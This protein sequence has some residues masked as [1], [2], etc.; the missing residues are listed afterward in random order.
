M[1]KFLVERYTLVLEDWRVKKNFVLERGQMKLR[2][3]ARI[4]MSKSELLFFMNCL[5]LK[6]EGR[7]QNKWL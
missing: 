4:G 5:R 2:A 7:D 3:L 1:G 6:A